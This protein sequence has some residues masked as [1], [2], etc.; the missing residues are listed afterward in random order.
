MTTTL[1]GVLCG[2]AFVG[3]ASAYLG[4]EGCASHP[5]PHFAYGTAPD[6][7]DGAVEVCRSTWYALAY[8]PAMMNPAFAGVYVTGKEAQDGQGGRKAFRLDPDLSHGK[9]AQAGVDDPVYTCG[10]YDRGHVCPSAI[11]S[12]NTTTDGPWYNTYMMSNIAPQVKNFNEH[13]WETVEARVRAWTADNN[14]NVHIVTG[15]AYKDRGQAM[16]RR[17]ASP[18]VPDYYW[19]VLCDTEAGQSVGVYG[20]NTEGGEGCLQFRT[21]KEVEAVYGGKILDAKCN[22]GAVDAEYWWEW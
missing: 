19:K 13:I 11:M 15:I 8:D 18:A 9:V 21:V 14:K 2:L 6:K 7:P 10:T 20:A 1:R 16:R 4:W 17:G 12:W 3:G 5:T 22:T